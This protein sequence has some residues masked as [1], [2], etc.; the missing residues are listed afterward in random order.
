VA[1][2]DQQKL[3][4][5]LKKIGFTK[6][7]T[8]STVGTGAISGTPKQPFAEAIPSPLIIANGALW[9]ESDEIPTT[10]PGSDTDQVKVYLA[11]SSGLRL[12][13]DATSSGQRA[14]IAYSTYGNTS[15]TRLTNWID[16]QFGA[17]YLIKVYK[18]DPNSGGVALSA[19]G[20]GSND[21]WFFDYS[22]G[23][24]NFNDTNVPSG[25]TDTN[26]YIVGYRYIGQTG[27][28]TSGIST[29]SFKDLTVERNLDVGPLGGISTFRNA[30]NALDIIKGYKYLAAPYSGT[31]TTFT[32]TVASK[33]SGQHRYHGQGSSLGYVIDGLQSPFFTLTPGN[34]Y[35]FDQSH[36][37]NSS[38]QIKFYLES[39]KTTLYEEGV[40]Y[41]G[42]AGNS[43]AYTQIVVS[44]KTP[45][46]LHYQCIN[47]G[48]MGNAFQTNANVVNTNYE[49]TIRSGLN[50]SGVSTFSGEIDANGRIVG[51]QLANVI[52]FYYDNLGQFPSSSTYHGAVAHAH[53]T[54]RL[55]FAHAGWKELVNKESNGTVGT[56]TETYNIGG[57]T[58]TGIDL[59][60]DIDVDGHTNLDNVSVV[61]VSTFTGNIDL[62]GDIDVDG[63]TNLDN[64][65]VA[66]VT[67][68]A[69]NINGTNATLSGNIN[70]V[71][72]IFS[73]NVSIG[74]T[75]TYEDVTNVDSVGLLTARS[76]IRVTGGVIEA[77]AGENKIPSLYSNMG[78]LPNPGTYHGMFAHVHSTGRGYF[79]HAGGWY[80]LVNKETNGTVGTGTET[81]NIGSLT[82]T[83]IDLNGDLDVD[84]HTNLDNVSIAG[85]TTFS[86]DLNIAENIIH[87]GD[88]D[89][90][91]SFPSNDTIK[92]ETGNNHI[93]LDNSKTVFLRNIRVG[94]YVS[95]SS[96]DSL[97]IKFMNGGT[98]N[99]GTHVGLGAEDNGTSGGVNHKT[100]RVYRQGSSINRV[101][102]D[103]F[104]NLNAL[105][106][107]TVAG[108]STFTG[109]IDANG[110][111]DVDGHTNLDNVS[112]AGVTTFSNNVLFEGASS[113]ILFDRAGSHLK[114]NDNARIRM[115]NNNDFTINHN[116]STYASNSS[117][118]FYIRSSNNTQLKL[119]VGPSGNEDA[120]VCNPNSSVDLYFNGGSPKLS[121][122]NTGIT[123]TGTIVADGADINGDLDVDGHTNLDNVNIV[124]VTTHE[125]HVLP[126]ADSTYDLGSSSKYWRHVYADNVTGGGGGVIIGDD[127]ITRNLQVNGISTHVGIATFNN[128]TF[129]D[130]VTFTTAN[131]NNIVFDKSDNQLE[132]GND[133]KA[134]FGANGQLEINFQSNTGNS[135]IQHT[136]GVGGL[137]LSG[138]NLDLRSNTANHVYLRANYN[139]GVDLYFANTKRFETTNTGINVTGDTET[140]TLNTGNATFTGT[141]SAGGA[142]GTS[143]QYLKSTGSGVAWAS[144]P[145]ARSSQV[146]TASAGQTTFSFSYTVGLVDVF[147]NGIKL[148]N[149][150]FTATNG[151]SIV[152]AVGSFVGDIVEILSYNVATGGG[153]GN[154]SNIVQDVT[155]QL[156]GNLDLNT[157]T[158]NGTGGINITGVATATKFVGDGSGLTGVTASGSG[159]I[160]KDNGSTVGTAQT[161]DFSTNLSVTPISAGIVTVT[162]SGGGGSATTI[163]NNA[164][165]RII[166]G[167]GTANTLEAESGLTFDG[168]TLA[169]TGSQTISSNLTVTGN[170]DANGDLDVDGHTN[171][172]NVSVAGVI[173]ATTFVGS[174]TG[175]A[176]GLSGTPNISVGTISGST[177]TFSGAIDANSD[178]DVD[179]H[180]NL[181]N[182]S[183]AGF[184][185]ITQDLDVDGH[186]NLDNVSVAGVI[187]A[188]TFKGSLEATSAS[189]S[190]NIDAN[191]DLDVDG[192]TNLDNVSIA[193]VVTATSFSGPATQVTVSDESSD[194]N[195]FLVFTN[196]ATG[197]QTAHTGT[198]LTFNSSTGNLSAT[199]FTGDGS[200]LT[201][202]TA[203]GSGVVIKHD[204]STVGTAGTINF[205]TNLDVSAISG[206]AVTIT[207]SGG[208][209]SD[210]QKNTVAGTDAGSSFSGSNALENTLVGYHAGKDIDSGD[211]NTVVGSEAFKVAT[212]AEKSI[213]IGSKAG[214]KAT[215]GSSNILFGYEVAAELLGGGNNIIV[216]A[217]AGGQMTSGNYNTFIGNDAGTSGLKG[218]T[219]GSNNILLGYGAMV[220]SKTVSNE[221]TIGDDNIS[222]FRIPGIGVSFSEGGAV[223]SG[224]VTATSFVG[225]GSGLTGISGGGSSGISTVSGVVSIA[226]DL[227]V[228]G[229]TNLDNVSVA[230]ITTFA[231][232]IKFG[233]GKKIIMGTGGDFE[234]Y[235]DT[236]NRS[237]VRFT[238]PEF[239]IMAAGG[240]T[241]NIQFG[242]SNSATELSY[243]TLMAEFKKGAECSLRFNGSPKLAT[244]NTGITV[245]G[246]VAAT[247]YTGDGSNLTGVAPNV[248]ITTNLS[249]SFTASA[250]SP[251][252][253]NTFGYG[254]G[255][256]VVEYTVF[257]K[258]GSNFQ[259]QKLL[260]MRDGT[261]IHSTQFAV[262]FSSSLLVQLDATISSG[263]IL[264]RATPET[265]V[266]GSTTYKVK[267]EV[268]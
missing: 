70:A 122:T 4:F 161:I 152:L 188:T 109:A 144:F 265:G 210:A 148:S 120:V 254:S 63:H 5:L 56:G 246:T 204:G 241:G 100:F 134:E 28:P 262:M 153:G 186:T 175:N 47:H 54:G 191:G 258:N 154:L 179:G 102:I 249:G 68:F 101:N 139:D 43:G 128:A 45:V 88:T 24:L 23:V 250:G 146:F 207:A 208:V 202:I 39:D 36:S 238:N 72:G 132:F 89:T 182:V 255:D 236:A 200:G 149:S 69:N 75:L 93:T 31:T 30:I 253:I 59:N 184:T 171:L 8:G 95:H 261:T 44:D 40:T 27:A 259:S 25:V 96:V 227:D 80:E 267:R 239:R 92:F 242:V 49:A 181:D 194:T 1:V 90:K 3:D 51:A 64:V 196:G 158:I 18:G 156:G 266:S 66:G 165:N 176:T 260:A 192:H 199:K 135:S 197:N 11:S 107:F 52:P 263:N 83:G 177:G 233:D 237:G 178:L 37:S 217:R 7:K 195:T 32:V 91:I 103:N 193:G 76:G 168:T 234:I 185:T 58:A 35:R 119:Q 159:V 187:T 203:S 264:L 14:Y 16:T 133:V 231:D 12:T 9:N 222:H 240:S 174:L 118:H 211:Y 155:P 145:T 183:I 180:T 82:A 218:T 169:V 173:T 98:G 129:H 121:T 151:T 53:S 127:I 29:F 65:S 147:V 221:V 167:S 60:G 232:D 20:S 229:H 86:S 26:I 55:Y 189:F 212:S 115:G 46:V 136:P 228:D 163:N 235:H 97:G 209:N 111:L 166:T 215:T 141:I 257:I 48:Y 244:S 206:G 219:T 73:G 94:D 226:N 198:N 106:G 170:I 19:A 125:G 78:A 252:T 112:I 205:G 13:A 224:V 15:S 74:G 71:D 84:G 85:V 214:V 268:M 33:I 42:S 123:V 150:E 251:S 172:D 104:G 108:I 41:N 34:T 130:D 81:Y 143:G 67:T 17:S 22:A 201:G 213:V 220:T 140:D 160:V 110:D 248:G 157:K 162:A 256:I 113:N 2:T 87:T 117:G 62:S 105:Q 6:T 223:V 164:N 99:N 126:S 245:T 10:P 142:T 61:G 243:Q 50:V 124:G 225:D 116:G 57:L 77:Q 190:S 247:S 79:S 216:G 114:F 21:G 138:N 131:G 137:V 38:H 230:G